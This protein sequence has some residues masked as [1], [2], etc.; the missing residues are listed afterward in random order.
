M[1]NKEFLVDLSDDFLKDINFN[2]VGKVISVGDGVASIIGLNEVRS[3]EMVEFVNANIKGMALNLNID[4]VGVV[5]FGSEKLIKEGDI[6][7]RT[8]NLMIIPTG[9]K[10]LGRVIDVLG[11]PIDGNGPIETSNY[12]KVEVKAPGIIERQSVREPLITGLKLVDSLIPI[13]RGQR[14]LIIGDRQTGKTSIAVDAIIS[15]GNNNYY[16]LKEDDAV[17]CIY[18]SIGQ[19]RSTVAQIVRVLKKNNALP[20]TVVVAATAS[21]AASLQFLAPYA[22]CTIGE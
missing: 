8:G 5:I 3:G 2:E 4:T 22:G 19:K 21:D 17:Y 1:K 13:G 10:L 16:G 11:N 7:K 14:E 9:E 15:Q 18:V 12:D 20:Y 6:V